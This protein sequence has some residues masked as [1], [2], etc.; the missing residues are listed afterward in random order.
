MNGR[1]KGFL[2]HAFFLSLTLSACGPI[3]LEPKD[4]QRVGQVAQCDVWATA[5][6][7][8]ELVS[9][10]A[11]PNRAAQATS[12]L[13]AGTP[14]RLLRSENGWLQTEAGWIFGTELSVELNR[15]PLHVTADATSPNTGIG[16]GQAFVVKCAEQW[17]YVVFGNTA[18]EKTRG[19]FQ[20]EKLKTKS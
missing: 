5:T 16:T 9:L 14:V 2:A 1:P 8:D 18:G 17:L 7:K 11:Q 20:T 13:A 12:T 3:T 15:Q 10:R 19:W 4:E 6:P